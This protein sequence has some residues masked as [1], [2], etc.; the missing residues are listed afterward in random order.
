VKRLLLA[1]LVATA[2]ACT[3]TNGPDSEFANVQVS[4]ATQ[5]PAGPLASGA[6]LS[7][8]AGDTIVTGID[9]LV[10]DRVQ[11]VLR[12]IE[13]KRVE[14]TDCD[15]AVDTDACEEFETGPV[16]VDLPL[17]NTVQQTFAVNV[18]I[19]SYNEI[20]FDIHKPDDGDPDDQTFITNNPTFAGI[21]IRVVGTFND[22]AYVYTSDL[23]VEQELA[24]VPT[25]EITATTGA[26]NLTILVDID[27][28]FRDQTGAVLD[29]ASANKDG[30][31]EGIV[32][33]NIK[34]SVEAFEDDDQDG[35]ED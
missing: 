33:E 25:L 7:L 34:N 16:L 20:E 19:G 14:T 17:G 30:P 35:E 12:E 23:N 28:W 8:A 6:F 15:S 1:M 4:F 2:A 29:P 32:K 31:N 11:V 21:S 10:I 22:S 27:S 9:T 24:L 5:R 18:P 26:A 13:L 3:T